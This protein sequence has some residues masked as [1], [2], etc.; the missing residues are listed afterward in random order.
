MS[1]PRFEHNNSTTINNYIRSCDDVPLFCE[2]NRDG[3]L[4]IGEFEMEVSQNYSTTLSV[5]HFIDAYS[6]SSS[7][8]PFF[9]GEITEV[10]PSDDGEVYFVTVKSIL[11]QLTR[12]TLSYSELHTQLQQTTNANEWIASDNFSL[13]NAQVLWIIKCMMVVAFPT[14]PY[15]TFLVSTELE[16]TIL[17]SFDYEETFREFRVKHLVLDENMLYAINQNY[18]LNTT[19]IDADLEKKKLRI[20]FFDFISEF[21]SHVNANIRLSNQ[22]K[23]FLI[24]S[25]QGTQSVVLG[26]SYILE[27]RV[28]KIVGEAGGYSA[29]LKFN[30]TRTTYNSST[31]TA[32]TDHELTS[33][34][35]RNTIPVFN[36]TVYMLRKYF[37]DAGDVLGT[38]YPDYVFDA[39]L[40]LQEKIDSVVSGF[41]KTV[42]RFNAIATGN[43]IQSNTK[44]SFMDMGREEIIY[45][46]EIKD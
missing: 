27:K 43:A 35:V 23:G 36:N 7:G 12:L 28:D 19:G 29:N 6:D 26:D 41:T 4:V 42:I 9:M 1:S 3:T 24:L 22:T 46:Y 17:K 16:E 13:P 37:G 34:D 10:K 8:T 39:E 31:P 20:T 11:V 38:T 2:K 18:A 32:L 40:F 33:G 44:S 15:S 45:T 25:L 21:C 14:Y 30:S 5:G